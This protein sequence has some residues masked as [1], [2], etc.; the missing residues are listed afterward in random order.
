[1]QQYRAG[2]IVISEDCSVLLLC[3]HTLLNLVSGL[4]LASLYLIQGIFSLLVIIA[5]Y[6]GSTQLIAY[7]QA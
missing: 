5:V 4:L 3:A 2:V 6:T 1:M 7:I